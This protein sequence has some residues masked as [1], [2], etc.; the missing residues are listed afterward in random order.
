MQRADDVLR[1]AAAFE[2]DRLA[3][4]ADIGQQIDAGIVVH[5]HP[6]VIGPRQRVVVADVGHH[7]RVADVVGASIEQQAFFEREV[8]GI[9]VPGHRQLAARR[10]YLAQ[11][12]Y[13]GHAL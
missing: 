8:L 13:I 4:P 7:Q 6:G 1:I 11:A 9:E 5:Q 3:V 10:Q 12:S 2:H